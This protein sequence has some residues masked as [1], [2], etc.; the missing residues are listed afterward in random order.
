MI[1]SKEHLET[2]SYYEATPC[3]TWRGIASKITIHYK[4][5]W[6][7]KK[8]IKINW[9]VS[10]DGDDFLFEEPFESFELRNQLKSYFSSK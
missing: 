8:V 1:F 10:F 5:W 7:P 3:E 9:I 2:I 6:K 4:S